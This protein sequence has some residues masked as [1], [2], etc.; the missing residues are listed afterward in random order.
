MALND[1]FDA[2]YVPFASNDST[3][4]SNYYITP[5][6][7]PIGLPEDQ[8]SSAPPK[9]LESTVNSISPPPQISTAQSWWGAVKQDAQSATAWA[10]N[11][12]VNL[13][14]GGKTV[15]S[16]VY[17]D[18]SSGV[19]KVTSDVTAPVRQTYWYILLAVVVVAGALYYI[20]KGGAVKV[21][22]IV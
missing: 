14:Q 15:V 10:E 16:T 19:G 3:T 1:P 21:N 7:F 12:A 20:G 5:A 8:Q 18:V 2:S 11:E 6:F 22:A 4:N 17:S 9:G 13:Y